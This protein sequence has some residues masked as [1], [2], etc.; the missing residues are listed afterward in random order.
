MTKFYNW[1]RVIGIISALEFK[2]QHSVTEKVKPDINFESVL[3]KA[4]IK[5]KKTNFMKKFYNWQKVIGIKQQILI[6]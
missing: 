4:N 2:L 6:C 5:L 3:K 1:Q